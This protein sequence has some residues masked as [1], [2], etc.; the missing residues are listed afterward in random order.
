VLTRPDVTGSSG[1]SSIGAQRRRIGCRRD[2]SEAGMR[3][4]SVSTRIVAAIA[5][6]L[7][8]GAAAHAGDEIF[9]SGFEQAVLFPDA[10]SN[11]ADV[12]VRTGSGAGGD[13]TSV[14]YAGG[15]DGTSGT[16]VRYGECSGNCGSA[17]S[18]QFATLGSYGS[19]GL[20]GGPR[21]ALD[22][23]GHPRVVWY[24][25]ATVSGGGTLYYG[26]CN[27][28]D[29]ASLAA[30]NIQPLVGFDAGDSMTLLA[31]NAFA[32]D[33]SGHPR[34]LLQDLL[35]GTFYGQCDASCTQFANWT[36]NQFLVISAQADLKFTASGHPRV[37]FENPAPNIL[38][39]QELYYA[40]CD[41][42]CGN[43][44]NWPGV[45]LL[46]VNDNL[47]DQPFALDLDSQDRPRIAFYDAAG[48]AHILGYAGCDASCTTPA[49]GTWHAFDTGLPAYSGYKG[50][51][52]ALDAS[53][54]P[55]LAYG[56]SPDGISDD[57]LDVAVCVDGCT[58]SP[59]WQW[60]TV[61]TTQDIPLA[62]PDPCGTGLS[63]WQIGTSP[64][65]A[66]AASGPTHAVFGTYAY[67]ACITGHDNEG[68]P[69]YTVDAYN[70]PVGYAE[71]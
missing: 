32:L 10:P 57:S 15:G 46:A 5:G 33:P 25:Q 61:A 3:K 14:L 45:A 31:R 30:W 71:P 39:G 19:A 53:D 11:G 21:L 43:E 7:V 59:T 62:P 68:N 70:G 49:A 64:D 12:S 67:F 22:P 50:V 16:P 56:A 28:A 8:A 63:Q 2:S 24:S 4:P 23:N 36:F 48:G 6:V 58:T 38:N 18:W 69:I 47:A 42:D 55:H 17:A 40:G 65:L 13:R 66:L 34:L 44:A 27:A 60:R 41:S 9:R 51:A 26:E 29:C 35:N 20:G 54:I 52:L 1:D 37:A